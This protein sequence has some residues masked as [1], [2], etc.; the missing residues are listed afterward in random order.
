MSATWNSGFYNFKTSLLR[1]P[2]NSLRCKYSLPNLPDERRAC[3]AVSMGKRVTRDTQEH[4]ASALSDT[5]LQV[6]S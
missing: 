5:K 1:L 2:W 6:T 3:C 4:I